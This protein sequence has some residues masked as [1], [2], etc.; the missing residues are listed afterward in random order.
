MTHVL[1]G[2]PTIVVIFRHGWDL[3]TLGPPWKLMARP[4][5]NANSRSAHASPVCR[6]GTESES[7]CQAATCVDGMAGETGPPDG[8]EDIKNAVNM[9]TGYPSLEKSDQT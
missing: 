8:M 3:G 5:A 1:P 6:W 4:W 2:Y 7:T 9:R